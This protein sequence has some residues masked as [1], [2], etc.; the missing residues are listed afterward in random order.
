VFKETG[1]KSSLEKMSR[2]CKHL[3][4]QRR[5]AEV[6]IRA[7]KMEKENYSSILG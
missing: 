5:E 6:D 1:N 7:D 4:E 2:V 3:L